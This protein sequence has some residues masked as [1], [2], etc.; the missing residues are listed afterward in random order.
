MPR[1]KAKTS[2]TTDSRTLC[3]ELNAYQQEHG[4]EPY[5]AIYRCSHCGKFFTTQ[6]AVTF[7]FKK[8]WLRYDM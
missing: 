8:Q 6:D 7:V 1:T 2:V 4:I 3:A 5:G